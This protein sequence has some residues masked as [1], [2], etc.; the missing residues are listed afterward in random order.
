K[1]RTERY[2][3]EQGVVRKRIRYLPMNEWQVLI[4]NH[5][6]GFLEWTAV[7][8]NQ[9][10]IGN[11]IPPE[12]HQAGGAV[13]ERN[14]VPQGNRKGRHCGRRLRTYYRGKTSA[15]GYYCGGKD[16][17]NGRGLYCLNVGGVSIDDAVGNA[18]LGAITPAAV[19]ASLLALQQLQA[20]RDVA[21]QQWRLE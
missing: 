13:R 20:N 14:A 4:P 15:P 8:A 17:V 7:Q 11:N 18:F 10:R 2:V 9:A 12:P 5:H 21:L 19:E 6:P 1:S 3:D 16:V